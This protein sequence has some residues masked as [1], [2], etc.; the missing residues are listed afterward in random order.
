MG[1]TIV[2][3][4]RMQPF[5]LFGPGNVFHTLKSEK[6]ALTLKEKYQSIRIVLCIDHEIRLC[7]LYIKKS[8]PIPRVP[9]KRT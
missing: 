5:I 2:R 4:I 6:T 3:V 1:K 7:M 9:M 8:F